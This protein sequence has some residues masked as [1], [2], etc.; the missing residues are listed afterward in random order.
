VPRLAVVT[1]IK[2][3]G[4]DLVEW[5]CFHRQVGVSR[6]VIYDNMSTDATARILQ[7]VPFKD[8]ITVHAVA[9]E[10]AQKVAFRDAIKRYRDELDW[11]AF[12]DG[13]E[14]IVP[15]GQTSLLTRLAEFEA[16]GV[17]GFGIHWRIFGSSG[18]LERPEGLV[19]ESF[20]RRAKDG[21]K[22]NRH[23][24]SVVRM[25]SVRSMVTQHYFR[26]TGRYLLDN[27][28]E[29]PSNF[30]GVIATKPTFTDG[31]AIH[32]YITKSRAQ[33]MRKIARGR[34][35]PSSSPTKYRPES[36]FDRNDRNTL[37][38]RNAARIIAPIREEVLRLRDAIGRD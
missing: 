22:Q 28:A 24:K 37:K 32:H 10:T 20:T 14:Y 1:C 12:I 13:D 38:D 16:Q 25:A 34:P 7:A 21:V 4:E 31:L 36:Y 6:F 5:L 35:R 9:D 23:V 29:P 17:S 11:V 19:T 27:G 33:C 26:V 3:E 30:E 18:L 15:F 8:E 2:N